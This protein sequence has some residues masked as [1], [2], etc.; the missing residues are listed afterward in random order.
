MLTA[1]EPPPNATAP[2]KEE[3]FQN[4]MLANQLEQ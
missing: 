2:E 1:E 4:P 3:P